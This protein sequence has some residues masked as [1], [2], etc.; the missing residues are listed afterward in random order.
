MGALS[1]IRTTASRAHSAG[2][3]VTD[4]TNGMRTEL[5]GTIFEQWVAKTANWLEAE[6]GSG[7]LLHADLRPHWLWPV[8]VAALDELEGAFAP[9]DRADAVLC[10]GARAD[11]NLP[12]IAV[13]DHPMA[14]PFREPLPPNHYDY[15]RDVR[16]GGDVRGAG[17]AHDEPL[18]LTGFSTFTA[19]QLLALAPVVP[20]NQRIALHVGGNRLESAEQIAAISLMSW[21]SQGSLV[22]TDGSS[23]IGG[24]K[25]TL[26][27]VLPT[28]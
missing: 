11:A 17:P 27:F 25:T 13:N 28:A 5:S 4:C 23:G 16:G 12:V 22:I 14:M 21:Q 6:F 19:A 20:A 7:V 3:F 24:E 9:E 26:D 18:L 8:L 2:P 15:F 1:S 10:M